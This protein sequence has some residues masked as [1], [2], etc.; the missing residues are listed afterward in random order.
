VLKPE[1]VKKLKKMGTLVLLT[2]EPKIIYSRIKE[3]KI[4]PLLAGD[5]KNKIENIL[6]DRNPIYRSVADIAIDTSSLSVDEVAREII[7]HIRTE[8][9]QL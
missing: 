2:A 8:G 5:K 7:R 3:S 9:E 6:K 1:N 4:R